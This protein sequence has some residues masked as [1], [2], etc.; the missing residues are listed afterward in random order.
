MII[1]RISDQSKYFNEAIEGDRLL[2]DLYNTYKYIGGFAKGKKVI[3][4]GCGYGFGT[5]YIATKAEFTLGLDSSHERIAY[6]ENHHK[7]ER[8]R[9]LV[10]DCADTQLEREGFECACMVQVVQYLKNPRKAI[11]EAGALLHKNGKYFIATKKVNCENISNTVK[12]C[13]NEKKVIELIEIVEQEGFKLDVY[14]L[15]PVINDCVEI[16]HL[17]FTKL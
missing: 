10:A 4:L 1:T 17:A 16:V 12:Y 6:A 3:D 7:H 5:Y 15:I 11:R 2:R 13:F 8:L 14:N 9:F